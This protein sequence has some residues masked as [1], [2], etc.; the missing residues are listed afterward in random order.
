MGGGDSLLNGTGNF[1]GGGDV[2]VTYLD[3]DDGYKITY[4]CHPTV[5][6]KLV[7]FM[8]VIYTSIKSV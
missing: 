2:N 8:Y 6:L 4:I 3:C 5:H 7:N 1:G